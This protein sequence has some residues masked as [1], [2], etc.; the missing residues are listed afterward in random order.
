MV[1]HGADVYA[2]DAFGETPLDYAKNLPKGDFM[3]NISNYSICIY[4][5]KEIFDITVRDCLRSKMTRNTEALMMN[6]ANIIN[7]NSNYRLQ[8]GLNDSKLRHLNAFLSHLA[9]L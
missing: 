1:N 4:Q 8:F 7:Y 2:K 9:K 6:N 5:G 3:R